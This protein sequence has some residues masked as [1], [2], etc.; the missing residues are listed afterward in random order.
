M[1]GNW[2]LFTIVWKKILIKKL[3]VAIKRGSKWA[4]KLKKK[5]SNQSEKSTVNCI[6]LK[7]L[8]K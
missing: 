1:D 5:T 8:L 6:M 4:E 7:S 3:F 2:L